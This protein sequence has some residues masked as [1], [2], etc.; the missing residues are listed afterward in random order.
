MSEETD[1]G[2][3]DAIRPLA[4]LPLFFKLTGREVLLAGGGDGAAWKAEL[5][6][7]AG[8]RV[9]VLAPDPSTQTA[10]DRRAA[11]RHPVGA[12]ALAPRGFAGR[13]ARHSG[14]RGRSRGERRFA[15]PRGPRARRSMS[16]TSPNTAIS[17]SRR[18]STARRSSSA[19]PPT[20][21]RRYLLRLFARG[22]KP[23]CPRASRNGRKPRGNGER[24]SAR[25]RSISASAAVSGS[26]LPSARWRARDAAPSPKISRFWPPRRPRARR[27]RAGMSFSSAPAPAIPIF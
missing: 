20:A 7:S 23:C 6:A 24:R 26:A 11:R 19:S 3:L 13:G 12:A 25:S 15:T 22:W 14:G 18:S 5:L 10:R 2:A 8:A 9:R 4:N 21:P 16:S 27:P 1:D 17:L